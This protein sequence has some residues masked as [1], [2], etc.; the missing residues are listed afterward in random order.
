M[1]KVLFFIFSIFIVGCSSNDYVPAPYVFYSIIPEN[2]TERRFIEGVQ[3]FVSDGEKTSVSISIVP[4]YYRV[5]VHDSLYFYISV[6]NK[7][8]EKF[9][10]IEE[11]FSLYIR[12]DS[13][14]K[15]VGNLTTYMERLADLG[16]I[17]SNVLK[18]GYLNPAFEAQKANT[19]RLVKEQRESYFKPSTLFK[20]DVASGNAFVSHDIPDSFEGDIFLEAVFLDE[21]HV[22]RINRKLEK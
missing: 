3:S 21:S 16:E 14:K 4:N 1:K 6:L 15:I 22:F 17:E 8:D 19:I 9:D 20:N 12:E 2:N 13:Q 10:A 11:G 18:I 7:S 5:K